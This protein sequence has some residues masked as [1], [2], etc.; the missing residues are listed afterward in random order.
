MD[1]CE[2]SH[3]TLKVPQ[4]RPLVE[5]HM[6]SVTPVLFSLSSD[7]QEE[8]LE[9]EEEVQEDEEQQNTEA[10][11]EE[12]TVMEAA[13]VIVRTIPSPPSLECKGVYHCER[14]I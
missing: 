1:S 5:R 10:A 2:L 7:D 11:A 14:S 12:R 8:M 13:P 9:S 6:G 4:S 3:P